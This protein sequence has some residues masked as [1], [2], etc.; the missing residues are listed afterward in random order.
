LWIAD[1][2]HKRFNMPPDAKDYG[3]GHRQTPA[4]VEAFAVTDKPLLLD[5]LDAVLARTK[6]YLSTISMTI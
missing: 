4:Q 5:Y 2:S 3:S 1:E 6:T